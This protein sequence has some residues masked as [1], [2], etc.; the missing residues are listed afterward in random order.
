MLCLHQWLQVVRGYCRGRYTAQIIH[1]NHSEVGDPKKS[2]TNR[3]SAL[4]TFKK[5]VGLAVWQFADPALF[6]ICG[7]AICGPNF[8]GDLEIPQI[9]KE[10]ICSPQN[11][12]L[13]Y[14]G[15]TLYFRIK[16]R[17]VRTKL[18]RNFRC[19]CH[20]RAEKGLIY[21]KRCFILSVLQSPPVK[22]LRIC[23]QRAVTPKKS[24][25]WRFADW[26]AYKIFGFAIAER[27]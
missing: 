14:S 24:A 21:L 23:N 9:R 4:R 15:S 18:R 2:S 12:D 8:L 22:N 20:E 10:I 13:K 3:K 25:G 7:F 27:A 26:D 11:I 1:V 17:I 5:F 16:K 19:F 6:A